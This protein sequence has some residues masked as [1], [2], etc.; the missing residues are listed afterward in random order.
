MVSVKEGRGM[1]YTA[2]G[3][4]VDGRGQREEERRGKKILPGLECTSY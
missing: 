3:R 1:K 4:D 2:R